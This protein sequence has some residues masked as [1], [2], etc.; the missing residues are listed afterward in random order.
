MSH[1]LLKQLKK[2]LPFKYGKL[3]SENSGQISARR[4]KA[5]FNGEVTDPEKV[6]EVVEATRLFLKKRKAIE[7]KILTKTKPA[8]SKKVK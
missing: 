2:K 7:R 4:V 3:I 1:K 8:K 6:L 5:V